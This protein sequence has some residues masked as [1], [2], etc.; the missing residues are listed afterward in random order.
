MTEKS[1]TKQTEGWTTL[2]IL[3]H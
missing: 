2:P 1:G 3:F